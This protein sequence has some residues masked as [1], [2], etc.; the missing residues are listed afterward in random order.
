[1]TVTLDRLLA[2]REARADFQKELLESYPGKTLVCLTVIVPGPVKRNQQSLVVAQA[3]VTALVSAFSGS[4][5]HLELRD[6]PTG[7]EG[8]LVT[9][10][11]NLEAKELTCGLE[12][13][14][15]LGRLF[16]LDVITADG[17]PLSRQSV[18]RSPRKCL[19]CGQ[20]AL[21]CMRNRTHSIDE[22]NAR[23]REM[24]EAYVQ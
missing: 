23:I 10:L 6:L 12:D 19:I 7:Y 14:H 17:T 24:I 1:M 8:Y 4:M 20:E 21:W 11:S 15:P 18:G 9:P 3:A 16:D 2:S 5:L 13:S 22:L